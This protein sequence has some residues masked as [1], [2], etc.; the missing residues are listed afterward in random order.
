MYNSAD[1]LP[2]LSKKYYKLRKESNEKEELRKE[3]EKHIFSDRKLFDNEFEYFFSFICREAESFVINV[4][5]L[6]DWCFNNDFFVSIL[7]RIGAKRIKAINYSFV[8]NFETCVRNINRTI[9]K[10]KNEFKVV[11]GLPYMSIIIDDKWK[12]LIVP[13][14]ITIIDDR[15]HI[16]R[17][18]FYLCHEKCK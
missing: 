1:E 9:Q 4:D 2:D 17:Y 6:D 7:S 11:E 10:K 5:C 15:T 12:I 13:E 3:I 16:Y 14:D 18:S 8:R